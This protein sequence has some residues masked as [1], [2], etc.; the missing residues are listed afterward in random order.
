MFDG[1]F[2]LS[3]ATSYRTL[4]LAEWPT[5]LTSPPSP[6]TPWSNGEYCVVTDAP[7]GPGGATGAALQ[8]YSSA[9]GDLIPTECYTWSGLTLDAQLTGAVL[10]TA[11][12]PAWTLGGVTAPTTDGTRLTFAT[13]ST[14]SGSAFFDHGQT[15]KRHLCQGYAAQSGTTGSSFN[16]NFRASTSSRYC[17]ATFRSASAGVYAFVAQSG[18]G[19]I[20]GH[21]AGATISTE[22]WCCMVV[23]GT[24]A[25]LFKNFALVAYCELASFTAGAGDKLYILGD[26]STTSGVGNCVARQWRFGHAA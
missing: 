8:I 15:D 20:V 24:V 4:T 14:N 17:T 25:K 1:G 13:T 26:N 9:Y 19:A 5:R 21:Q 23:D 2:N 10:P 12:S 22:A 16:S 6:G 11:E 7:I 18:T 3:S